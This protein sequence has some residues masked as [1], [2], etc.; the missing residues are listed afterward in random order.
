MEKE[1]SKIS[2]YC[3]PGMCA[4]PAIYERIQ[5]P[6][7]WEVHFLSWHMPKE[8]ESL[9]SYVSSLSQEIKADNPILVGV[10]LGG[11][12]AQEIAQIKNVQKLI[13]ISTVTHSNQKSRFQKFCSYI[14]LHKFILKPY[15]WFINR[16]VAKPIGIF[17]KRTVPLI[18]TYLPYRD[19]RYVNWAVNTFIDWKSKPNTIPTLHLHGTRDQFF[20]I[21]RM[22]ENCI[23]VQDGTHSMILTKSSTISKKIRK[24]E[25]NSL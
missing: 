17:F 13:L 19:F 20:P 25:L 21:K 8:K 4:S 22:G 9:S 18:N 16:M 14:P 24:F 7:H 23:A 6:S 2:V 10:S 1:K 12:M 3:L 15:V 11:V 5:W